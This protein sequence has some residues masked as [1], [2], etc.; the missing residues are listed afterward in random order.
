MIGVQAIRVLSPEHVAIEL[1]AAG[2]G[3]RFLAFLLD[4]IVIG[5]ATSLVGYAAI[6]LPGWLSVAL[7]TTAGFIIMWGYHI[8]CEVRWRG[9]SP[10]KRIMQLRVVDARGLPVGVR[11]SLVR[12]L[13]RALDMV[14]MGG[15]GMAA[16]LI[17]PQRRRLGDLAADTLVVEERQPPAPDLAA[18]SA[19]RQNSLDTP[20][21]RRQLALRISLEEREFLL[22]LCQRAERID[23][24][25]R[26]SL[27]EA[28]GESLRQ[29]LGIDQEHLSGENVVRGTVALLYENA[30]A[31]RHRQA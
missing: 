27:F 30:L 7:T 13:I 8:Y 1:V 17:D 14:P 6:M 4:L 31:R 16:C 5:A 23:Q 24:Q 19:R 26:F 2:F 11:Q 25:A 15:I 9:Q 28:A 21:I 3:R 29:R 12:N 10:G 20:R 18:L 22:A